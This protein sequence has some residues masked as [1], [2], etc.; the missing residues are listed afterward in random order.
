[1]K[2]ARSKDDKMLGGVCGG[3]GEYFKVDS[4]V[5][6]LIFVA[7][8][9]LG[10]AGVLAY[11]VLW[12]VVPEEG[13]DSYAEKLRRGTEAKDREKRKEEFKKTGEDI[14]SE[15]NKSGKNLKN[16][17]DEGRLIFATILILL[18][19]M[20]LAHNFIPFWNFAKL[21]PLILVVLGLAV[22]ISSLDRE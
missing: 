11:I 16:H 18:G 5:V 7:V 1:M 8:T 6:R 9:V 2:L 4:V 14:V 13:A 21:W 17:K 10:G 19:L 22:L 12:I 3:L 15:L 20:F